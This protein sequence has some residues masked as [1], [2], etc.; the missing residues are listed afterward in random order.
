MSVNIVSEHNK[1]FE[2]QKRLAEWH[3]EG[4]RLRNTDPKTAIELADKITKYSTESEHSKYQVLGTILKATCLCALG[5][6]DEALTTLDNAQRLHRQY[7]PQNK[8]YLSDIFNCRGVIYSDQGNYQLAINAFLS[9]LPLNKESE[10]LKIYTNLG[11]TY[12]RAGDKIKAI[13][14]WRKAQKIAEGSKDLR[15]IITCRYNIFF[16]YAEIGRTAEAKEGAYKLLSFI[17]QYPAR[18]QYLSLIHI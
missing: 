2:K 16:G 9:C 10:L 18:Q 5:K 15:G 17:E 11:S 3:E 6:N 12:S 7:L 4:I 13:E 14:Y 8:K 1:K